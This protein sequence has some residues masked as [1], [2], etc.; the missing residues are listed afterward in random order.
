MK[1]IIKD[2]KVINIIIADDT[3]VLPSAQGVLIDATNAKIGDDYDADTGAFTTPE[4]VVVPQTASEA[5]I[6]TLDG[7]SAETAST[8]IQQFL[9]AI[10]VYAA[11]E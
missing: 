1:A 11:S 8:V 4:A 5:L 9:T 3:F 10:K 2:G 6:A 7:I